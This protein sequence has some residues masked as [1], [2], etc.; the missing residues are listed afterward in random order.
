M[1]FLI[2]SS[3][4]NAFTTIILPIITT[5]LGAFAGGII[6][7]KANS[8]H[9][10]KRIRMELKLKLW[11]EI[12]K[13]IDDIQ[14]DI[15]DIEMINESKGSPNKKVLSISKIC[16][17]KISVNLSIIDNKTTKS[18]LILEENEYTEGILSTFKDL[19]RHLQEILKDISKYDEH[20]VK[21]NVDIFSTEVISL[22]SVL[23]YELTKDI[24][25]KKILKVKFKELE[26]T[27]KED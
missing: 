25:D 17:K 24:I 11:E 9:E 26:N 19:Q 14:Q 10:K 1:I 16:R 23:N 5:L 2:E 4:D 13:I 6:T 18:I 21:K 3:K 15:I 27:E 8:V 22:S 20:R 7:L 12:S